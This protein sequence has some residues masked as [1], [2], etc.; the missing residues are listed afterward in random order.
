MA[1]RINRLRAIS[2]GDAG[3]SELVTALPDSVDKC[4][5]CDR[6]AGRRSRGSVAMVLVADESDD[7]PLAV[8]STVCSPCSA[9]QPRDQI[10]SDWARGLVEHY[11]GTEIPDLHGSGR[12]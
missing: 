6:P 12:A 4:L 5:C 3:F 1:F 10:L 8:Y 2:R 11:G 7:N 9:A